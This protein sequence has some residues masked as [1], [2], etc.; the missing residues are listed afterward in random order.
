MLQKLTRNWSLKLLSL[1]LGVG[2]W[3]FVVGQEKSE[4]SLK[5]PV[6]LTKLPS[7]MV[8]VGDVIEDL[9]LRLYGPKML[10]KRAVA[11][12]P[13]KVLDLEGLGPGVHEFQVQAEDL[14]LPPG[15]RVT[16]VKPTR[17][18]VKLARRRFRL[19]PV[20]PVLR[21]RP[22]KGLE[23]GEVLFSP[24]KVRISGAEEDIRDLDWVWTVPI[25]VQ[26]LEHDTTRV[27]RLRLPSGRPLRL[28]PLK[29]EAMIKLKKAAESTPKKHSG[30]APVRPAKKSR[31]PQP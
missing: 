10:L 28:E 5:V 11:E 16:R 18:T 27:V 9:D 3:L 19:V 2:L 22:A 31:E 1:V 6:A 24:E 13:V 30:K 25:S 12:P 29:V 17:F 26:G 20:R 14:K 21:G 8:V 4:V 7:D 23:V 15:V